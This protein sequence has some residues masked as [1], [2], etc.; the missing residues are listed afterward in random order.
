MTGHTGN[1]RQKTVRHLLGVA[2]VLATFF[3]GTAMAP[4]SAASG[5]RTLYL[6][7]THTN[8]TQRITFR[9]NGRYDQGGLSELNTFLRDWR[10]NEP[11]RMDPALFDLL[12]QVYQDVGATKPIYIVSAY[13]SPK[14][15]ELLRS[16]SNGVA[17][18]STH[19][20]GQALDFYI[21]GIPIA[22][23][24]EAAM[25][26]QVGGV[27]YYPTSGSPFVHLDTGNV[28]AWP[29]MTRA[30]LTRIFPDG[31]TLHLPSD[32]VPISQDGRRYATNEYAKCGSIP[33]VGS[34]PN[35]FPTRGGRDD[36]SRG[37]SGRTWLDLF[38]GRGE[39][40][41]PTTQVADTGP[42]QRNVT[43]VAITPPTPAARAEFLDFRDPE[44]APV[45]ATMPQSLL[46]A[47]RG[48]VTALPDISPLINGIDPISVA[49]IEEQAR[50]TPRILLSRN[51]EQ[52]S[53]LTAYAPLAD[54]EPDAQR[55]L[56]M[57]I[58]RRN[59]ADAMIASNPI[60]QD[61][62]PAET[63]PLATQTPTPVLRGSITTASLSPT[64]A[65]DTNNILGLFQGTWDA[66]TQ[67]QPDQSTALVEKL[68]ATG[69][70]PYLQALPL[71]MRK[72]SLVAPDLEHVSDSM[73]APVA[74]SA[75]HFAVM[76]EPDRADFSPETELGA[77]S[78]QIYFSLEKS[79]NLAT[80][81]FTA[82]SPFIVAA[83]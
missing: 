56:Q 62:H 1:I 58:E 64:S 23:L 83:L 20:R 63:A 30:Q 6:Y 65:P 11:T 52:S 10:R 66:L 75:A 33:C 76:F 25:R 57:L 55:A 72:V 54:P 81:R 59:S 71:T 73:V 7:Y 79:G 13:R 38:F 47:T 60:V 82:Q 46:I 5:E 45:P 36:T 49:S 34:N 77:Q 53:A 31:R 41:A 17:R 78:G 32:G 43:S 16:R 37:N 26:R 39:E 9:R 69:S 4:L 67:A 19:T 21:P 14:T 51:L 24:R 3:S 70:R 68:A 35:T 44:V 12:W 80:N 42:V 15:N 74:I 48:E 2:V 22:K 27:G 29:R 8:E 40:P 28:R 18:N 50:P 61:I